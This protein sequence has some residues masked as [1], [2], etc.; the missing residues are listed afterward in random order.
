MIELANIPELPARV[1]VILA[2]PAKSILLPVT[3][4][5]LPGLNPYHPNHKIKTPKNKL[6]VFNVCHKFF[7]NSGLDLLNNN[8]NE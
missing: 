2:L 6:Y 7:L 4:P 8:Y 3:P 5:V 1:V